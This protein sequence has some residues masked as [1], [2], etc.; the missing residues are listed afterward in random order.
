MKGAR[1][2][3]ENFLT[4]PRGQSAER[5]SDLR[6]SGN[7]LETWAQSNQGRGQDRLETAFYACPALF[8][9]P[10]RLIL[11]RWSGHF[12]RGQRLMA[13]GS[14]VQG[15]SAFGQSRHRGRHRQMT[16]FDP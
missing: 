11:L 12:I 5:I 14:A 15:R 9:A 3:M 4:V 13:A 2:D 1:G 7:L 16:D 6:L 10:T 8:E